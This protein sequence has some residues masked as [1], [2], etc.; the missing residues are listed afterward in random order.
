MMRS[1]IFLL[2]MRMKLDTE[3]AKLDLDRYENVISVNCLN[4][5]LYTL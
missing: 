2:G 4:G 5:L 3:L 1:M